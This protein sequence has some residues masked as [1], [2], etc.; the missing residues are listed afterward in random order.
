MIGKVHDT[1]TRRHGSR[2]SFALLACAF[3]ALATLGF[4]ST[5]EAGMHLYDI[6]LRWIGRSVKTPPSCSANAK[7]LAR[8]LFSM[9]TPPGG[10][11]LCL[12]TWNR[13]P[14]RPGSADIDELML[15]SRAAQMTEDVPVVVPQARGAWSPEEEGLFEGLRASLLA[16][17][18]GVSLLPGIP[19]VPVARVVVIDSAA[20]AAHGQITPGEGTRHGDTL[21][22]LIEDLV[23][24]PEVLGSPRRCA[25]EVTTALA[26]PWVASGTGRPAGGHVGTP[27]DLVE[28]IQRA[29]VKWKDD[30]AVKPRTTPQRLILNLSLGWEHTFGIADC[31]AGAGAGDGLAITA[32]QLAL[33][34]AAHSGVLIIAAA[35]N[36]SGGPNPRDGLLCPG[37]FQRLPNPVLP[38]ASLLYAVSGLDAGDRPLTGARERGRAAISAYGFGGVAW[39]TADPL[40][41]ALTGSSVATAVVSAVAALML[42]HS[43]QLSNSGLMQMIYDGGVAT[44]EQADDCPI[45]R[46]GCSRMMR[47]DTCGALSLLN[48]SISCTP[49]GAGDWSSPHLPGEVAALI[50]SIPASPMFAQQ[51]PLADNPHFIKPSLQVQP[52]TF[53]Q[54]ISVTCPTCVVTASEGTTPARLWLPE[55]GRKLI[56]PM[57][58]VRQADGTETGYKLSSPLE[59]GVSYRFN[60]PFGALPPTGSPIRA[61]YISGFDLQQ[62]HSVT[63]E[64]FVHR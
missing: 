3:V 2:S 42:A 33:E 43:P 64:I 27:G 20:D 44:N 10:D 30:F 61:A 28:A 13:W 59:E 51:V 18:G 38:S 17:V 11:V 41:P 39:R 40:P 6:G 56:G 32:V 63:E 26:L 7:W 45:E 35:G 47:V 34:A 54:P 12:Y 29:I 31:P 23:C 4:S 8:P 5:A 9:L 50:A 57:L 21:A 1:A 49:S 48:P 16:R 58:V 22:H 24:L 60:L 25:A 37:Y 52:W 55:M 62:L 46:S 36:Q 53:P 19:E 15:D 14:V